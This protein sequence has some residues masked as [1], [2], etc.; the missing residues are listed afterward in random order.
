MTRVFRG[1]TYLFLAIAMTV[2]VHRVHAQD[3]SQGRQ[4]GMVKVY[5]RRYHAREA[6]PTFTIRI[7]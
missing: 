6:G 5:K 2:A 4:D 7:G 1:R 3:L